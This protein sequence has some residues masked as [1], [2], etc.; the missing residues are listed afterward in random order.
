MVS[1]EVE[2]ER[3]ENYVKYCYVGEYY[4][5]PWESGETGA[6]GTCFTAYGGG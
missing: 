2:Y 6:G 1:G 3:G 4:Y 5:V